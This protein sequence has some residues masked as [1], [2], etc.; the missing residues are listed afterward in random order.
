M[1][2]TTLSISFELPY[3]ILITTQWDSYFYYSNF[4]ENKSETQRSN[5][6]MS[7]RQEVEEPG[8]EAKYLILQAVPSQALGCPWGRFHEG[9]GLYY[10]PE[11]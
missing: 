4:T 6:L 3:L 1:P 8:L 9:L 5:L 2:D 7:H 11:D 10:G